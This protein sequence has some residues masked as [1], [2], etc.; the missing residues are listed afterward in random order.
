MNCAALSAGSEEAGAFTA[1]LDS[2]LL[3]TRGPELLGVNCSGLVTASPCWLPAAGTEGVVDV[4]N[5]LETGGFLDSDCG[6]LTTATGFFTSVEGC[7]TP[8]L[9]FVTA[10]TFEARGGPFLRPD[11][12]LGLVF[13]FD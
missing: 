8:N 13:S 11:I 7:F 12:T 9:G 5:L 3:T 10:L 1:E 6:I 2:L 4:D